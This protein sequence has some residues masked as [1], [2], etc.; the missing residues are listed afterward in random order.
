[1]DKHT[2]MLIAAWAAHQGLKPDA[3]ADYLVN[4]DHLRMRMDNWQREDDS[5]RVLVGSLLA[6]KALDEKMNNA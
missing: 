5:Y 6:T 2:E 4:V 1:M 3:P